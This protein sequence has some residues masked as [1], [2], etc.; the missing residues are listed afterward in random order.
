M[1]SV[2]IAYILWVFFGLLGVHRFYCGRIGTGVLWFFT[3]GLLGIGWLIDV[4][5]IP[6]MVEEANM[7]QPPLFG[8]QHQ[9]YGVRGPL[10][11]PPP[12]PPAQQAGSPQASPAHRVIYCTQC[13]G[14]M[15]VPAN[16]VGQ[17]YAC[18][19]CRTILEVPA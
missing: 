18:P 7:T 4:F 9:Q 17:Q 13:G 12:V 11:P 6:G 10:A 3:G 19:S 8:P 5:L 1:R 15:Q 14:A 16:A 2:G